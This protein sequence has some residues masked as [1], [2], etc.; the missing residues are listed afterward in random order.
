MRRKESER[1]EKRRSERS[2]EKKTDRKGCS[3]RAAESS[4]SSDAT[5]QG[6][7]L[8]RWDTGL[9]RMVHFIAEYVP[10]W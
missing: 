5:V 2:K 1:S 9:S 7:V 3:Q 10:F 6:K 4:C 8:K